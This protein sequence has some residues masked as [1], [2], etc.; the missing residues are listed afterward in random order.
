MDCLSPFSLYSKGLH[1]KVYFATV[2]VFYAPYT[3]ETKCVME[4]KRFTFATACR[5]VDPRG[6]CMSKK[7]IVTIAALSNASDSEPF[8]VSLFPSEGGGTIVRGSAKTDAKLREDLID[9][10]TAVEKGLDTV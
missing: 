9:C 8:F 5:I 7:Y 6:E 10:A 2:K 1:I 3:I 4:H